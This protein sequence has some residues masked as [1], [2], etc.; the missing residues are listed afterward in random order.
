M[1]T[2]ISNRSQAEDKGSKE[3]KESVQVFNIGDSSSRKV[4]LMFSMGVLQGSKSKNIP[5]PPRPP[6][7]KAMVGELYNQG[8]VSIR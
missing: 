5:L 6:L 2:G 7:S 4:D 8:T 3:P 1:Y